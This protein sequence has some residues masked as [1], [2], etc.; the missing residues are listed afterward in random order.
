MDKLRK[1]QYKC[2][3]KKKAKQLAK[4]L[5]EKLC[6]ENAIASKHSDDDSSSGSESDSDAPDPYKENVPPASEEDMLTAVLYNLIKAA[7][8]TGL[9]PRLKSSSNLWE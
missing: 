9:F 1:I 7:K 5:K 6:I 2:N 3:S 8:C 4:Q